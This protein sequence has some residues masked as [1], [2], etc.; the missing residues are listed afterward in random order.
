MESK[1]GDF[2][3]VRDDG[4]PGA[5]TWGTDPAAREHGGGNLSTPMTFDEEKNLLYVPGG[6]AAPDI[7]DEGRPGANLYTNSLIALDAMTGRLAWYRQFIP[8]DVHDYD[9]THVGPLFKTA[10][11]GSTRNVVASTGKDGMLRVLDRD[12]TDILYSVPFTK[13]VLARLQ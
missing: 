7:Y 11:N 12:S 8:H 9:V 10:I 5:S 13:N 6:N 4:E 3:I 1:R 2:N